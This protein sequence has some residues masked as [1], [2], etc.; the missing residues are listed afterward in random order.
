MQDQMLNPNFVQRGLVLVFI[1]LLLDILGIA[2]ICPV[3]PEY[4]SQLTGKDVSTSFVERG[5]LLAAYSVMQFLFAPF[6][7]N[8]SDRYGRRPILLL[9]IICFALDNLICAIAWSYSMLFIGRLLSGMSGASFAT[10]T[11]YLADISDDKTRTRNF[12]LLGVASALGFILGSFIGGFLGQF[13][14]RIPFYFAAG[15]SLI[16]FIFSW[17]ML[18]ETLSLWNRRFFDIKRA[19][20]L[21]AFWHLKQYPM[22]LWVLLVFFLYWLAE[23]V[24][25]SIWA[26]IAKERYDWSSF[27]IGLSYSVF[28]VG[29]FIVVALILPYFSKRWSDWHIVIVGLL[30][31][32]VA[33]LG[34]TFATQGWMVY[35]VCA[36]TM[37]EYLVHAPIRA[38]ASARV[39]TNVQ[40]E[41][42]GAMTSVISLSLIFGSVFYV[43]LFECFTDKNAQFYFSGAPFVGGFFLLVVATVIFVLRVR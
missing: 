6:I 3:L 32:S 4:F 23:S 20:P 14:P 9:S 27:S 31:A 41:L 17:V 40:G 24:W 10:C 33:M 2:I 8:L 38:I 16:N 25:L 22:V 11:A 7:G 42:Q 29:Q 21:G 34:Y 28:G 18:P 35:M 5:K 12:G 37:L 19:N 39:P 13:G 36:C 15:F 43:F 1:T 26:F 30:F